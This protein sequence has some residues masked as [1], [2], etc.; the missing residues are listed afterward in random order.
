[1]GACSTP[2]TSPS[3]KGSVSRA[4][5]ESSLERSSRAGRTLWARD[6]PRRGKETNAERQPEGPPG[7]LADLGVYGLLSQPPGAAADHGLLHQGQFALVR[8]VLGR[9]LD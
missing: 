8:R 1:M 2:S 7:V 5:R 9:G 6:Q 4:F 3:S